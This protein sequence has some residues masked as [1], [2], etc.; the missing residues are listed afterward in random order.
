MNIDPTIFRSYDIRGLVAT[1]LVDEAV[2]AIGRAYGTFAGR[3][4]AKK[5]SVGQDCRDSSPRLAEALIRGIRATGVSVV[6]IGTVTTPMQYF[7]LHQLAVDGGIQITGSHNPPEYNGFKISVGTGSLHGEDIQALRALIESDDF[8]AGEGTLETADIETPYRA[9]CRENVSMGP[10]KLKVVVDAGNGTSGPFAVPIFEDHGIEVVPLFCDMDATFPNH[11]PDPTVEENLEHLKRAV[12]EHGAD[13]GIAFDGDGDRI[14]VVDEQTNVLWGDQLM[15]LFSRA[16]L[17]ERPGATIV[18]EVKCSKV[19]YDDIAAHGGR[20]LMWKTGHSLI[21]DKMKAEKAEL[22]GEMSGHIFF[23]H[24]FFGF[25]D[26]TYAGLRLLEI[27]SRTDAP[28]SSLLA[29]VP[30]TWSTPELRVDC[31]EALKFQLVQAAID[32]FKAEGHD[33]IDVDGARVTFPDGW[34]LVRA[35]NTGPILVMRFEAE[36]EARRDEIRR[37]VETS[38]EALRAKL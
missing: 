24:R 26:A 17:A 37:Y 7:S 25:D 10:R 23:K 9:W 20:G 33:V 13:L 36:T 22:A 34:G 21:K 2:E 38:I 31:P 12:L 19:L 4:G 15:I 6:H 30:R 27:V 35:S 14:G 5:V 11:H 16:I 32:F 1:Q 18:A 8:E 28:V 3:R 29:D